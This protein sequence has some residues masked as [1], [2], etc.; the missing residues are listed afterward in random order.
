MDAKDYI[1]KVQ[2]ICDKY[3]DECNNGPCPLSKYDC[4]LPKKDIDEV[5]DFVK[6]FDLSKKVRKVKKCPHC[7][8]E[9]N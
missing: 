3:A 2:K 5:I 4:G 6:N 9:V 1:E 8:K 7:G